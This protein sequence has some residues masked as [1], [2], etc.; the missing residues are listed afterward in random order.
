[1]NGHNEGYNK[2]LGLL[3][4]PRQRKDSLLTPKDKKIIIII[5]AARVVL[6]ASHA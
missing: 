6:R 3:Q 1:M 2:G 4:G 5:I